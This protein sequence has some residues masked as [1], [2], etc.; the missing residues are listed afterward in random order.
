MSH[1]AEG[2]RRLRTERVLRHAA[3]TVV[4]HA[5]SR[6]TSNRRGQHVLENCARD[7]DALRVGEGA[8]LSKTRLSGGQ[9]GGVYWGREQEK[10]GSACRA[11]LHACTVM[12]LHEHPHA[13]E[14]TKA[15]Q[16]RRAP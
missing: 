1:G 6:R 10:G 16:Q 7:S 5:L 15:V 3:C 13:S 9:R 4:L 8:H 12:L 14:Q 11:R 2:Q